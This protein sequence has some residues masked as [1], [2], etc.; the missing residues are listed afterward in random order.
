MALALPL[1]PK[2]CASEANIREIVTNMHT[3]LW[4]G[5]SRSLCQLGKSQK[6]VFEQKH[7]LNINNI[8]LQ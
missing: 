4:D 7:P 5:E 1:S 2:S 8:T 6:F 3:F